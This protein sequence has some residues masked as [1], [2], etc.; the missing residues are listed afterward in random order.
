MS[1]QLAR[2]ARRHGTE[3]DQAEQPRRERRERQQIEPIVVE[4]ARERVIAEVEG[5]LAKH[6]L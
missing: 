5:F 1:R 4:D 6:P 3:A 2:V